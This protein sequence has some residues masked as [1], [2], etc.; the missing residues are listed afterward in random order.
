MAIGNFEK[1]LARVRVYEGGNDDDPRDPGGRTSRGIIQRVYDRYRASKGLPKRDVWTASEAEVTEIY[2]IDYWDRVRGDELPAGVDFAVFDSAVNSGVAQTAKWA[3]RAT[4]ARVD[5]D[6]GPATLKALQTQPDNDLLI[7]D[8]LG[9]RLAM[10]RSLKT[11]KYYGKGWS[12]RIANVKRISQAW[13]TGSVG[14]MPVA[15]A[16][17]GG[18]RKARVEDIRKPLISVPAAQASTAAS[19]AATTAA[20][21]AEQLTPFSDTIEIIKYVAAGLTVVAVVGGVIAVVMRS[22]ADKAESGE[23]VAI[24]DISAETAAEPVAV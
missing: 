10:V 2:R 20:Q 4:G 15:V 3:Q 5:G 21:A 9:R 6:F 17:L 13:A 16:P 18:A 14:P 12:A 23:E 24:V 1:C 22:R 11:W 8:I 19:T 7:A